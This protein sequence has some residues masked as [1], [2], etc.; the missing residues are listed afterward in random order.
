MSADR[1][2]DSK[3]QPNFTYLLLG[4]LVTLL[5]G[6]ICAELIDQDGAYADLFTNASDLIV[7]AS[8]SLTL[9]IGIWSFIESRVWFSVGIVL[10]IIA[11]GSTVIEAVSA[12]LKMELVTQSAILAFCT[13]T[14]VIA[15]LSVIRSQRMDSNQLMAA[16]CI[17]LLLGI[18][19]AVL[20]MI[21]LKLIPGSFEGIA[22]GHEDQAGLDM[23]YFTFVTMTTL[24]YGD[25]LP[26]SPLARALAYMAAVAG[27]FYVALLVGMMVGQY[28]RQKSEEN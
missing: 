1:E 14:V 5:L 21:V 23:I 4:L 20:N 22:L 17:Y 12:N 26:V 13:L 8:F 10:A 9:I 16:I 11:I 27:Q 15:I 2:P 6:P 28:L 25:I 19:L 3:R 18:I 7:Q 24:G